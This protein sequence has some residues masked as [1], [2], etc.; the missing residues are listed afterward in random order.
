VRFNHRIERDSDASDVRVSGPDGQPVP[1]S[2]TMD[3]D[4]K[5][6][7]F[8]ASS[9][10]LPSGS[11]QVTLHS[12]LDGIHSF[13]GILDGDRD[14]IPGGDYQQSF[15]VAA[16]GSTGLKLP[17]SS[18]DTGQ[19]QSGTEDLPLYLSSQGQVK[20]I[21]FSVK[22]DPAQRSVSHVTLGESLPAGSRIELHEQA[23]QVLKVTIT[24]PEPLAPGQHLV[25]HLHTGAPTSAPVQVQLGGN[26]ASFALGGALAF[27]HNTSQ[28]DKPAKRKNWQREFVT[29]I[30]TP[31][32]QDPNRALRIRLE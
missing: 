14:G 21:S 23:D 31:N 8:T 5:G 3:A 29:A 20:T 13:F 26:F 2:I 27:A 9:A 16:P 22:S 28:S 24:S 18:T 32:T 12:A 25:A 17:D 11:Y 15:N 10:R 19:T 7:R 1:G 6:L 30:P 4:G